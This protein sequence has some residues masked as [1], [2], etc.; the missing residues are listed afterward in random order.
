MSWQVRT[1]RRN[2]FARQ[3][4]HRGAADASRAALYECATRSATVLRH[5]ACDLVG[6]GSGLG[7]E[8]APP[9]RSKGWTEV[10]RAEGAAADRG[11]AAAGHHGLIRLHLKARG[12]QTH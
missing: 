3:E 6:G 8:M 11:G 1:R 9:Q 4:A 5:A 7:A 10:E 2:T 12:R